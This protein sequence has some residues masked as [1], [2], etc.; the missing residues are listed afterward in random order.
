MTTASRLADQLEAEAAQFDR[1]VQEIDL[2]ATQAKTEADRQATRRSAAAD[3]LAKLGDSATAKEVLDLA[4][5]V[6]TLTRRS[7]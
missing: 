1:E 4:N 7:A 5:Q 2:L 3:K 6:V